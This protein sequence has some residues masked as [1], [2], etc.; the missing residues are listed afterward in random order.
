MADKKEVMVLKGVLGMYE[1]KKK[2][3]KAMTKRH[4]DS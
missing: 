1:S 3:K 4:A 2:K